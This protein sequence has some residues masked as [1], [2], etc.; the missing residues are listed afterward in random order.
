MEESSGKCRLK[1]KWLRQHWR[2]VCRGIAAML[3]FTGLFCGY[4]WFYEAAPFRHTASPAWCS[5]HSQREYWREVQVGIHRVMWDHDDALTVGRFGDKSWAEWI[6]AHVKPGMN[7]GCSSAG[8]R[9]SATAMRHITNQDA[10][11]NADGWLAWWAKNKSKS[12]EEWIADGFHQRGFDV[13]VPPTP[14]QI[15]VLLGLL[16]NSEA[17]KLTAIPNHMKYNAFRCLRDSGF[18]PVEFAISN[19]TLSAEVQRG[20][21]EYSKKERFWPVASGVGILSFGKKDEDLESFSIPAILEPRFQ[22]IAYA[23]I[24]APLLLGT[25][26]LIWSFRKKAKNAEAGK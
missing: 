9:R 24:F 11:E 2:G 5:S 6:M 21:L 15:P 17:D 12:Q 16:G 1:M 10:G 13:E 23:L 25:A 3:C 7:M 20:L 14:Q 4:W 8:P 19:R 26:L 18:E 22:I